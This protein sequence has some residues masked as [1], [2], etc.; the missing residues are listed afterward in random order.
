[1]SKARHVKES[2]Q[3]E[4][5]DISVTKS[6]K[7]KSPKFN[8]NPDFWLGLADLRPSAAPLSRCGPFFVQGSR[9]LTMGWGHP[10]HWEMERLRPASAAL[11][12]RAELALRVLAT[13][14]S[15]VRGSGFQGNCRL[16]A[17]QF[18]DFRRRRSTSDGICSLHDMAPASG[19]KFRGKPSE[20]NCG[21]WASAT[22]ACGPS[23]FAAEHAQR[24]GRWS[25]CSGRCARCTDRQQNPGHDAFTNF[26]LHK[27]N[28]I[29]TL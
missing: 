28:P 14:P 3:N 10:R 26:R 22:Q 23:C 12:P 8:S 7:S 5:G 6:P 2:Y 25:F 24:K 1:M 4:H 18:G 29:Q 17:Q 15:R 20:F 21:N 19:L 11:G 9:P 13:A 27:T 16:L